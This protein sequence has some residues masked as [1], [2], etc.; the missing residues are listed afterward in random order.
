[1][2]KTSLEKSHSKASNAKLT[3]LGILTTIFVNG[4]WLS[5]VLAALQKLLIFIIVW[6]LCLIG[7]VVCINLFRKFTR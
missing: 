1:M 6:A 7:T 5:F 4:L 3:L 2:G